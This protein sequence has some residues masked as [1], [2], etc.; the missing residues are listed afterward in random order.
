MIALNNGISGDF[1][2]KVAPDEVVALDGGADEDDQKLLPSDTPS[3]TWGDFY[4]F[5]KWERT[6]IYIKPFEDCKDEVELIRDKTTGKTYLYA[7]ATN[8][9]DPDTE[10]DFLIETR[11]KCLALTFFTP[12]VQ[13]LA[14]SFN[15]VKRVLR[16]VSGYNFWPEE[17]TE[18]P[19]DFKANLFNAGK[20]VVRIIGTPFALIGLEAAAIYGIIS[21]L[22]G[23]KL[24]AAIE[25]AMYDEWRLAPCFQ[26]DIKPH[27]LKTYDEKKAF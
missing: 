9:D 21:P 5:S 20:D 25:R 6:G 18:K 26:P 1:A 3:V 13:P 22:N 4:L 19:Y 17:F 14:S 15:V 23:R 12:V 16:L 10:D 8:E 24:Y 11:I 2:I 27:S 7:R